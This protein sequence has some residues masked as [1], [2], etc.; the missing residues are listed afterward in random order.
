VVAFARGLIRA[1]LLGIG[2]ALVSLASAISTA[3]SFIEPGITGNWSDF[4]N[5]PAATIVVLP[6]AL[7][8]HSYTT[9]GVVQIGHSNSPISIPGDTFDLGV[10][11]SGGEGSA[12]APLHE[13]F[14]GPAQP[15]PGGLL[16]VVGNQQLTDVS[17]RLEWAVSV[18]PRSIFGSSEEGC[19]G[20]NALVTFNYC[21]ALSGVGTA[22]TLRVKFHLISPFL[23][24]NCYIGSAASPVVISLT[25]GTSSP[26]PSGHSIH[27]QSTEFVRFMAGLR[28]QAIG[29][30]LVNNSFSVPEATG[31]STSNGDLINASIDKKL[32]L[33][34]PPGQNAIS[35]NAV[36]EQVPASEVLAHGWTDE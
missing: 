11:S 28:Q 16:G 19:T 2:L 31:C 23:S 34:S 5:C 24:A 13:I 21:R 4:A 25:S 27:G 22:A 35:I 32:G 10:S 7:C 1:G 26:P 30:T 36:A 17:A 3:A 33:P 6:G 9:S 29:L 15:V 14:A 20:A 18:A 12:I 8:E